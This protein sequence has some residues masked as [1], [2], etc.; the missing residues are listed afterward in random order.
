MRSAVLKSR[1]VFGLKLWGQPTRRCLVPKV[2]AWCQHT[3]AACGVGV[4]GYDIFTHVSIVNQPG[5]GMTNGSA[6]PKGRSPDHASCRPPA[7]QTMCR[8]CGCL[9]LPHPCW[10]H[11]SP[12]EFRPD[13]S[14]GLLGDLRHRS[15]AEG[16]VRA[17]GV[18]PNHDLPPALVP[19]TSEQP[20]HFCGGRA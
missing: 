20:G 16:T 11:N 9:C 6:L 5:Y 2:W 18:R 12:L 3:R 15:Q 19:P 1:V 10:C 7:T 4:D 17:R 8:S 14:D 13:V